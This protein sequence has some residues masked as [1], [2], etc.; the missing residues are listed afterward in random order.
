MLNQPRTILSLLATGL[1]AWTL[2]CQ[3]AQ[4]VPVTGSIS[5]TGAG[6][7]TQQDPWTT[8]NFGSPEVT[9]LGSGS[10][11]G[12]KPGIAVNF[13][14]IVLKTG[15]T[16]LLEPVNSLWSFNTAAANY[17]F[18]LAYLTYV[19]ITTGLVNAEILRGVGTLH[20]TGLDDAQG[21]FI[22]TGGGIG[23]SFAFGFIS[24]SVPDGGSTAT[25]L[26]LALVGV[27]VFRRKLQSVLRTM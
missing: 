27:G 9:L 5:F 23:K 11:A 26:G 16:S 22:L 7:I 4:A 8:I 15:A 18:D 14:S 17:S 20:G 19:H 13:N 1:I 2:F 10:Y 24:N 21:T 3:Q 25:L 6:T 12:V